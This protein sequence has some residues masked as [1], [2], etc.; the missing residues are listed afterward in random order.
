MHNILKADIAGIHF[1]DPFPRIKNKKSLDMNINKIFEKILK[2]L[3]YSIVLKY[4]DLMES[5]FF[6]NFANVGKS[7][8]WIVLPRTEHIIEPQLNAIM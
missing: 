1:A 3:T 4:A 5:I 8:S 2:K 6:C 7:T